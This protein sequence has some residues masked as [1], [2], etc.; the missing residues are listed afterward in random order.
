MAVV[1]WYGSTFV[2]V[3]R[4]SRNPH[5]PSRRPE[6]TS[7][8]PNSRE[9]TRVKNGVGRRRF[10]ASPAASPPPK[11]RGGGAITPGGSPP[12]LPSSAIGRHP[13]LFGVAGTSPSVQTGIA[14]VPAP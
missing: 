11:I 13:S 10:I 2:P 6:I 12:F 3:R 14:L 4:I 1:G 8:Q 5:N 9:R 7:G